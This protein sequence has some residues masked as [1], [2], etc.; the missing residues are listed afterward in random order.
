MPRSAFAHVIE[1]PF[2]LFDTHAHFYTNDVDKYPFDSRTSRY[3]PEIMVAKAMRF[4]QT[5]KEVFAFWEENHIEKGAGVQYSSTYRFNNTYLLDICHGESRADHPGGDP[6]SARAGDAR[7]ARE[8]GAGEQDRRGALDR[9]PDAGPGAAPG[10]GAR[11]T[12]TSFF[13]PQPPR[14]HGTPRTGSAC[15]SC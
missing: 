10:P 12:A 15:S 9:K 5:P 13:C 4:P 1:P 14:L 11:P 2:K 7:H 3:G 6:R 8:D